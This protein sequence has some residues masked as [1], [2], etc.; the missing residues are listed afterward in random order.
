MIEV[1]RISLVEWLLGGGLLTFFCVAWWLLLRP[2][3]ETITREIAGFDL[4]SF[5]HR[6]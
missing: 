2:R 3:Q 5:K 1:D 4:H 6:G